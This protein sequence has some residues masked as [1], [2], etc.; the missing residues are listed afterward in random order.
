MAL[1]T[2]AQYYDGLTSKPQLTSITFESLSEKIHFYTQEGESKQWELNQILF[3][4]RPNGFHLLNKSNSSE[5]L[6]VADFLFVDQLNDHRAEQGYITWYEKLIGLSKASIFGIALGI[7]SVFALIYLYAVPFLA[8]QAVALIPESYDDKLGDTAWLESQYKE[9]TDVEKSATLTAFAN[10]LKL[11]NR[12]K[13]HFTVVDSE[14]VNA[15]AMPDGN[16]VVF[17]GIIDKM[18]SYE[19]LVGLLGHEASHV[20]Q[21][22]SMKM[23][24]R[25]LSGYLLVSV[26]VG[27]ANGIMAVLASNADAIQSMSFSRS[28]ETE[29][30][31]EGF[32]ILKNNRIDPKGMIHLFERLN[33]EKSIDIPEFLSSHPVTDDRIENIN[34]QIKGDGYAAKENI[35]LKQLFEKLKDSI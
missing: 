14:T 35:K 33:E 5:Y 2:Q 3:D 15:F 23:L 21:R 19:E 17:T 30:D 27:D 29:A 1:N 26:L 32:K 8:E 13:L 10:S 9:D 11:N 20:N 28:F 34:K 12:K 16:I 4:K 7:L 18:Q 31:N 22:H 6:K 25:S 24:C